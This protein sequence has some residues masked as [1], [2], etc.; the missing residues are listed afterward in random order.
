MICGRNCAVKKNNINQYVITNIE[1][2]LRLYEFVFDNV[3]STE[4]VLSEPEIELNILKAYLLFNEL[5]NDA[6]NTANESTK[7]VQQDRAKALILAQMFQYFD[8]VN[9]SYKQELLVQIE[10]AIYLYKFLEKRL[11]VLY[12]KY[13]EYYNC[14]SWQEIMSNITALAY[15]YWT[16][17]D[18]DSYLNLMIDPNDKLYEWKCAFIERLTTENKVEDIDFRILRSHPFF[19][20][21][22]GE[23][24][25]VY[26]YFLLE[27]I[28]KGVYFKLNELNDQLPENDK[29]KG[30][31]S[32]YCDHF[33][34]KTLLYNVTAGH[35]V[36]ADFQLFII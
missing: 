4:T 7:H 16:R 5:K 23:Y 18:M 9:Y 13:I 8:I 2:T 19:K 3:D 26:G 35:L 25:V 17:T 29:I 33:S 30:F 36:P 28:H 31:R 24:C 32:F 11:P 20:I 21:N 34:E 10:K 14:K 27:L 22:K 1:S 12:H 6:E 15:I